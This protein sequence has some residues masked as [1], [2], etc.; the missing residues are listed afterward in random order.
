MKGGWGAAVALLAVPVLAIVKLFVLRQPRDI[1]AR[2][3]ECSVI[4]FLALAW[5][6]GRFRC[7]DNI[8]SL[9]QRLL[10]IVNVDRIR[11]VYFCA[12]TVVAPIVAIRTSHAFRARWRH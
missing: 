12:T 5:L 10:P 11:L 1:H 9:A 8:A 3:P 6:G 4:N 7:V 2:Q